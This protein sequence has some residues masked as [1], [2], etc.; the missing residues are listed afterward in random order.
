MGFGIIAN[1][2]GLR[3]CFTGTIAV[4]GNRKIGTVR[5]AGSTCRLFICLVI[6]VV[7]DTI[8]GIFI[9][10]W[11]D[12]FGVIDGFAGTCGG[13]MVCRVAAV[14]AAMG[15]AV[16]IEVFVTIAFAVAVQITVGIAIQLSISIHR[17]LLS[18]TLAPMV[19]GSTSHGTGFADANT[20]SAGRSKVARFR[21]AG[22]A[23]VFGGC[24][25]AAVGD[26]AVDIDIVFFTNRAC[27]ANT[28][29][30]RRT[31]VAA[32]AAVFGIC[33]QIAT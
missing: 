18:D 32:F 6:A 33:L 23:L 2:H 15:N 7:V 19:V 22:F 30:M 24:F 14:A 9:E 25:F 17:Q 31:N 5:I 20:L 4:F 8:G 29:H 27:T 21:F 3:E 16:A 12:V 28:G 11:S 26:I 1:V 13:T 10:P